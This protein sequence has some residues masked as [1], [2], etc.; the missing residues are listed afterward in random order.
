M[1]LTILT[2]SYCT[3][4]EADAYIN[5]KWNT[6]DYWQ[7]NLTEE[8]KEQVLRTAFYQLKYSDMYSLPANLSDISN[9]LKY[10][11]AE[12]ALFIIMND[13]IDMRKSLQM[14]GVTEAGIVKE[15]YDLSRFNNN[16][17]APA[18]QQLLKSV[19][20]T[21]SPIQMGEVERDDESDV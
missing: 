4:D 19:A 3:V 9:E 16:T 1:S 14:Q 17:I 2:D 20:L 11:Q 7:N 12:Q 6:A 10:A 5:S 18:A 13:G 8:E 21:S 15:K